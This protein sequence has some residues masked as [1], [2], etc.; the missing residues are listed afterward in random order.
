MPKETF[1][2][3]TLLYAGRIGT[4]VVPVG[5]LA[6]VLSNIANF[7]FLVPFGWIVLCM[8]IFCTFADLFIIYGET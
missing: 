2:Y 8:D 5:E 1:S 7:C 4:W 6:V 3:Q